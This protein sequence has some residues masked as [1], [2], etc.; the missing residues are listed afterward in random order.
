MNEI[1]ITRKYNLTTEEAAAY[2]GLSVDTVRRLGDIGK[3]KCFKKGNHRKFP[4]PILEKFSIEAA[5]NNMQIDKL[6]KR[7]N[8]CD[9]D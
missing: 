4:K 8:S 3:L 9:L 1:D 7:R 6:F 2:I 5:E